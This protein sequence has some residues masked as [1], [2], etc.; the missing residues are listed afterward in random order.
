MDNYQPRRARRTLARTLTTLLGLGLVVPAVAVAP[1]HAGLFDTTTTVVGGLID[2]TTGTV[3]GVV[4]SA[5]SPVTGGTGS[6]STGSGSIAGILTALPAISPAMTGA[7]RI[8]APSSITGLLCDNLGAVDTT[9]IA[10]SDPLS[11]LELTGRTQVVLSAI[12]AA[13]WQFDGWSGCPIPQDTLCGITTS[14]LDLGTTA[15]SP[16]ASFVKLPTG[17][18]TAPPSTLLTDKPGFTAT[19]TTETAAAFAFKAVDADGKDTTG[20]TYR[21]QLAGPGRDLTYTACNTGRVSYTGLTP[22]GYVFSVQASDQAGNLDTKGAT[23]AWTVEPAP[24]TTLRGPGTWLLK[25]YA[26]FTVGARGTAAGFSCRYDGIGRVCSSSSAVAVNKIKAGTHTFTAAAYDAAGRSDASPATSTFTLPRN[27]TVLK[28]SAGWK[29]QRGLG[30]FL[31]TFSSTTKKGA[32]LS[33]NASGIK[34]LALVVTKGKGYGTVKVYLGKKLLKKVSLAASRTQANKVVPLASFG[35]AKRG[36]I[37]IV[38]ATSG[39]K[40]VVDGLGV[41]SR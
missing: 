2:T 17:P 19:K 39:K 15:V 8:T 33:A 41:A 4:G 27:N 11:V 32:S 18:D 21:C 5:T 6:G 28:H 35:T 31:N 1:A 3:T 12:P 34:K 10:C 20:A 40:V 37:R 36:T 25:N 38:V 26:S 22:G 30:H 29:K 14:V 24:D 9:K 7:G 16:V 13:G 23:A